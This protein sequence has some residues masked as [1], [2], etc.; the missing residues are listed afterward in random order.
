MHNTEIRVNTDERELIKKFGSEINIKSKFFN[1]IVDNGNE[2]KDDQKIDNFS[3]RL[4]C[5][6]NLGA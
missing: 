2:K 5:D 1:E 4:K 6:S 3:D